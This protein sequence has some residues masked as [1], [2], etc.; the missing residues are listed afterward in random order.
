MIGE[1]ICFPPNTEGV[2]SVRLQLSIALQPYQLPDMEIPEGMVL[3]IKA[4]P[5][6]GAGNLVYI[7]Y[8]QGQST[9][10][11]DVWP[12]IPNE[13]IQYQIKNANVLWASGAIANL[14]VCLTCEKRKRRNG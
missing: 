3:N 1:V 10:L 4:W 8:S 5:L 7:G 11:N 2:Q 6:N 9:N 14:F 13:A 12:L